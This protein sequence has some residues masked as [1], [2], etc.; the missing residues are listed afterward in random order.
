VHARSG[1][2]HQLSARDAAHCTAEDVLYVSRPQPQNPACPANLSLPDLLI[3]R[4]LRHGVA[5]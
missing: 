3:M 5:S 4:T 2:A 1:V